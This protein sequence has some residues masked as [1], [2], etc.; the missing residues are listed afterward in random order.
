MATT[1][2]DSILENLHREAAGRPSRNE[3][4]KR[5][6]ELTRHRP[7]H[8]RTIVFRAVRNLTSNYADQ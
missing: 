7:R 8:E 4:N 1:I 5:A 6:I 2:L 3:L